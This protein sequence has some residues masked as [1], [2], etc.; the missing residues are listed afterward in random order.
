MFAKNID[1]VNQFNFASMLPKAASSTAML[2]LPALLFDD[3]DFGDF[4]LVICVIFE[5]AQLPNF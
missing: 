3:F 2:S 1:A 5:S 4:S